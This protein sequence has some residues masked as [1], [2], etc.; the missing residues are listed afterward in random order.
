MRIL[1][2]PSNK[3]EA[4]TMLYLQQLNLSG[5]ELK[6]IVDLYN[7]TYQIISKQF[8]ENLEVNAK[9]KDPNWRM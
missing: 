1:S 4:L 7:S 9:I 6:E 2:F 3:E 5:V 8:D